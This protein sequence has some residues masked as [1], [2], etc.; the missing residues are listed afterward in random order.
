MSGIG[1]ALGSPNQTLVSDFLTTLYVQRFGTLCEELANKTVDSVDKR[2]SPT[3]KLKV[4][5]KAIEKI[6]AGSAEFHR[7]PRGLHKV[8]KA[9]TDY[10]KGLA[11]IPSRREIPAG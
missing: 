1:A 6:H 7:K 5:E 11:N 9:W 3:A 4:F 2:K 8:A 10:L